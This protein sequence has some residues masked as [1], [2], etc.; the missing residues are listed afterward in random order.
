MGEARGGLADGVERGEVDGGAEARAEGRGDGAAPEGREEARGGADVGYRGREGVRARLL[1][2]R[3][4]EVDGLEEHGREHAGA[5][6]GDEVEGC[7]ERG[8]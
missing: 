5:E 4:E 3:L 6:A 1:D 2:T 8:C 7:G